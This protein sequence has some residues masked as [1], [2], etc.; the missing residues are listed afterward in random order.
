MEHKEEHQ[1]KF[2][3]E[4]VSGAIQDLEYFFIQDRHLCLKI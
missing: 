2:W 3:Q 4:N 1:D